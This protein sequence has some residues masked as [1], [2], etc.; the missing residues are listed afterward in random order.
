MY[1]NFSYEPSIQYIDGRIEVFANGV[2]VGTVVEYL[3]SDNRLY[4]EPI[5]ESRVARFQFR[6]E[7][8]LKSVVEELRRYKNEKGKKYLVISSY[9]SGFVS[10][11]DEAVLKN[12][13]FHRLQNE[14]PAFMF[15]E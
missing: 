9:N 1:I 3:K 14:D 8:T 2:S 4:W 12:I 7:N 5:I 10:F 11:L 6:N 13:G 15:L